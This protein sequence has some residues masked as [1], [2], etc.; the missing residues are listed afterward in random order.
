L[1]GVD[2]TG[3]EQRAKGA[4]VFWITPD[5]PLAT[6]LNRFPPSSVGSLN[7]FSHGVPGML[8][9]RYNWPGQGDYGLTRGDART[10]APSVF[11]P[12][13]PLRFDSCNTATDPSLLPG[14][15]DEDVSLAQVVANRTGLP[16]A[17]W[18]GRTSYRLVNRGRGGVIGSEI[19]PDESDFDPTE[20][21]SSVLR[22][23]T[24]RLVTTA[25]EHASGSFSSWFKMRARLPQTRDFPVAAG[26]TVEVT[27]AATSADQPMQGARITVLLH[28][29]T[30]EWY[31]KNDTMSRQ[32]A[33]VGSSST[34]IWS[35]LA[36][37]TYYVELYHLSGLEVEGTIT[38]SIR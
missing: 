33:V 16:V 37:G 2:L 19:W 14:I 24:P 21:Y 12:G 30:A 10:L 29:R 4:T 1:G 35:D 11:V 18:I 9:L 26:A 5:R 8:T 36:A 15:P 31:R 25:P 32:F 38:V 23:R 34:L 13:A 3:I 27:I 6:L 7:V 22:Q 20:A 28:R 17:A